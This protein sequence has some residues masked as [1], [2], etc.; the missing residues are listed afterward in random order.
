MEENVATNSRSIRKT[1]L[2]RFLAALILIGSVATG[3]QMAVGQE[4]GLPTSQ[5]TMPM[6]VQPSSLPPPASEPSTTGIPPG[7]SGG[8][9][10]ESF[11]PQPPPF[12]MDMG[13]GQVK[14][15]EFY[16]P[17][18]GGPPQTAEQPGAAEKKPEF[19][20]SEVET[21]DPTRRKIGEPRAVVHTSHGT[22][23]IKLLS[24]LAP[25]AVDNFIALARGEKTFLDSKTS[26]KVK[27]PFFNGLI[28]HRVLGGTLV[29]TGCP[30]GTGRG[31]P[32][33]TVADE[34]G[35]LSK[36]SKKGMVAMA[37]QRDEKGTKKDTGGS[38]FFI[39]LAPQPSWNG[40]YTIFGE[41]E[42]GMDVVEKIGK[43]KT[44][45]T[46]RPIKKVVIQSVEIL[47]EG[48]PLATSESLPGSDGYP[49]NHSTGA[50]IPAPMTAP[51]PLQ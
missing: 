32:G 26:K 50:T 44:G 8:G 6:A 27:R 49:S 36:F 4:S 19:V 10:P 25:N 9:I 15:E 40:T 35:P 51:P 30:F 1:V 14:E 33:Y 22:F 28:F 47:D 39:T 21:Y 48:R 11:N 43:T 29:Q 16:P 7:F 20:A 12:G 31:G 17:G 46:D 2:Q 37:P 45:P 24:S 5:P 38:Q 18:F 13:N 41:V 42:K 23:T 34:I 3:M